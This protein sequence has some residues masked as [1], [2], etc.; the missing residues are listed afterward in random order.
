MQ[1]IVKHIEQL[2]KILIQTYD[3]FFVK[4]KKKTISK[5]FILKEKKMNAF[6]KLVYDEI[7]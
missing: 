4:D 1:K 6:I 3:D 5:H 2:E 7:M